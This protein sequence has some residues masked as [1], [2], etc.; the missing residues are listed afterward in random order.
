[1]GNELYARRAEWETPVTLRAKYVQA[2]GFLQPG[3]TFGWDDDRWQAELKMMRAVGMD[4]LLFMPAAV[5]HKDGSGLVLYP[6]ELDE[7]RT[8]QRKEDIME[9]CLRNCKEAG[10]K[11]V[12]D[13]FYDDMWFEYG[14]KFEKSGPFSASGFEKHL[15][16]TRTLANRVCDEMVSLYWKDYSDVIY[17]W[18]FNPEIWNVTIDERELYL[19]LLAEGMNINLDHYSAVTPGVPMLLSPFVNTKL[20]GTDV[21][22]LK[23]QWARLFDMTRFRD[24][25]VLCPQDSVGAGGMPFDDGWDRLREWTAA[26]AETVAGAKTRIRFWSNNESFTTDFKPAPMERFIKQMEVTGP[27]SEKLVTFAYAHY[28]SP[29]QVDPSYHEAYRRYLEQ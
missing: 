27:F 9:R 1:M 13:T 15:T 19:R 16:S 6:S 12:M 20:E 5:R 11:I 26:Y 8:F 7:L 10:V 23:D 24:G 14:W 25:D 18:Y 28:Y 3:L 21:S 29:Y 4:I 2:G 22:M 17:S